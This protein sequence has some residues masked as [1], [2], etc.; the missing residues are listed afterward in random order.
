MAIADSLI[1]YPERYPIGQWEP[2]CFAYEDAFF[3]AT[4]GTRLHGWFCAHDQPRAVVL[5]SH[6]NAGNISHRWPILQAWNLQLRLSILMY[7]YRGYGRSEGKPTET[8]ILDDARAARGWLAERTGLAPEQIAVVGEAIGGAVAV[9]LAAAD[10]A[11]AV[12]LE[13]TFSSL[14]EVAAHHFPWLPVRLFLS[15]RLDSAGKIGAYR[16]PLLQ[17]HGDADSI[18]PYRLGEK[19]FAAANEPKRLVTV[20]GGDHNDPPSALYFNALDEFLDQL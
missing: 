6:G 10:G 9:D 14:A 16:G 7:D 3:T 13:N 2:P 5:F 20:P 4:D 17:T 18:V 1:F 15:D 19:L 12:V 11:R 8:G